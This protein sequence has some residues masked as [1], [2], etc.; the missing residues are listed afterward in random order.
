MTF[1]QKCFC[2]STVTGMSLSRR[3]MPV[4]CVGHGLFQCVGAIGTGIGMDFPVSSS[5]LSELI[6]KCQQR[7]ILA[8]TITFQAI[9][10]IVP[11]T[12]RWSWCG[13]ILNL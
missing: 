4:D 7:Q 11:I 1:Y 13:Y 8:T 2:A 12:R 9:F 5:Y 6:P 3:T 10:S